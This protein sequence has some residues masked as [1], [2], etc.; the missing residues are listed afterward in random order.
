MLAR[1][2]Q[3]SNKNRYGYILQLFRMVNN[4]ARSELGKSID[5]PISEIAIIEDS[6]EVDTIENIE[7]IFK[8]FDINKIILKK[9]HDTCKDKY[10][11]DMIRSINVITQYYIDRDWFLNKRY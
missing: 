10:K 1:V 7:L 3:D 5:I 9:I 6:E 8:A 4:L 11:F 2:P